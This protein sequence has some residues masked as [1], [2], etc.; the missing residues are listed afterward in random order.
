MKNDVL[1]MG[2]QFSVQSRLMFIENTLCAVCQDPAGD[3]NSAAPPGGEGLHLSRLCSL[4][5]TWIS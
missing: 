5:D 4:R 1:G 3:E 2:Q